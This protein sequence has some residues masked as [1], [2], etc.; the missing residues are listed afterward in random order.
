MTGIC[1]KLCSE[2]F[3]N[4]YSLPDIRMI[5]SRRMKLARHVAHMGEKRNAYRDFVGKLKGRR[6]LERQGHGC[7][8]TVRMNLKGM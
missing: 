8:D 4:L 2:E 1:N 3:Q 6:P 7:D 5:K